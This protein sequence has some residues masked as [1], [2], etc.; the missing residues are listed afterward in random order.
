MGLFGFIGDVASA[1]VKVAAAPLAVGSDII[2]IA[3]GNEPKA[4]E[5]L[6]ES[7][8]DSLIDAADEIIP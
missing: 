1:A 5:K 7:V 6:M 4:T 3:T 2:T 8:G